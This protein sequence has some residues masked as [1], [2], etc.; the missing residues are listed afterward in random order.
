MAGNAASTVAK[1]AAAIA[2]GGLSLL[3]ESVL[4]RAADAVDKTDY[5]T[6]ALAGKKVV[7]GE[8]SDASSGSNA[9]SSGGS[10]QPSE[11]K[12]GVEGAA[13]GISKGSEISVWELT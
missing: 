5:C 3:A 2:T 10:A 7:P 11:Q 9:S 6:P 12:S 8:L 1:G 13:D 4:T